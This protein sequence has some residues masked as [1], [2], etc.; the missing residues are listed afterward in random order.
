MRS[1]SVFALIRAS[2]SA[3]GGMA[4]AVVLDALS[5][6]WSNFTLEFS[7]GYGTQ[8]RKARHPEVR[9]VIGLVVEK[10]GSRYINLLVSLL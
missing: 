5:S 6:W 8:S 9:A 7:T 4:W 10:R 1:G 2:T 3:K